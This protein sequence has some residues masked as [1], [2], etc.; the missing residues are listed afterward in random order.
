MA[1][2]SGA[3]KQMVEIQT[4]LTNEEREAIRRA[5]ELL[6][7]TLNARKDEISARIR[8]NKVTQRVKRTY[9]CS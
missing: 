5:D 4:V 7:A 6:L 1:Q 8:A 2:R 3:V 9:H